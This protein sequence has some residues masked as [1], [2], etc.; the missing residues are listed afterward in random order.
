MSAYRRNVMVG[1]TVMGALTVLGWMILKFGASVARP[2][3]P[4]SIPVTFETDRADG[5]ADG[6]P[7]H[8]LGV[9]TGHVTDVEIDPQGRQH[10]LI[11]ATINLDPPMPANVHGV[12]K[13]SSLLGSGAAISL[14]TDGPPSTERLAKNQKIAARF[15]G[16]GE[17]LPP[18]FSQL[19]SELAATA[20]QFRE[21]NLVADL[22]A[23]VKN[24]GR[25]IDS[26]QQVVG[27]PKTQEDLKSSIA[28]MRSVTET[29]KTLAAKLD[30]FADDLQKT[31]VEA[32]ATIGDARV[33]ITRAGNNVESLSR[34]M[35]DRLTQI[36]K[37]LDQF[38]SVAEKIDK[39]QGSAGALVNDPRLYESLLDTSRELNLTIKDFKRLVEQWEQEG[40]S[41][42]VK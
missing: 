37:L 23:Q 5:V 35:G 7:I 41:L 2:F 28:N 17:L 34:Q 3:A 36:A 1:A 20:K 29:A 13:T 33:Q 9:E 12:I 27:D 22:D 31:T 21:S 38:Q 11:R 19:A 18:E 25:V 4:D 6:S 42:K 10:V 16:Y 15:I 30:K 14:V 39:G 24:A 26:M 32:N 40:V 8:Y